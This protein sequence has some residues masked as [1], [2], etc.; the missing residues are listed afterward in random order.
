MPLFSAPVHA[1]EPGLEDA[2]HPVLEKLAA[3]DIDSLSPREAL[4][5]L[6][7]LKGLI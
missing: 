2:L 1:D 5:I 7:S 4:D 3:L 6:Y